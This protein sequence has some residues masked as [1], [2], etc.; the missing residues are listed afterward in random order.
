MKTDIGDSKTKITENAKAIE[1][2]ET[3]ITKVKTDVD[4]I[5]KYIH[6]ITEN[7]KAIEGLE[8]KVD[9]LEAAPAPAPAVK[10]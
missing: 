6:L 9:D 1:G 4:H 8:K 5:N 3:K 10:K 2:F 7:A